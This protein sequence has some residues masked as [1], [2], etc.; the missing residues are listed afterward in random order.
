[1]QID[2]DRHQAVINSIAAATETGALPPPGGVAADDL[3]R[4]GLSGGFI[5]VIPPPENGSYGSFI[6]SYA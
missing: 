2:L 3:R 5:N 1:V 6:D 4:T